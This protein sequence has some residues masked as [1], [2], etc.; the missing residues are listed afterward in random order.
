MAE[1]HDRHMNP[2]IANDI[3]FSLQGILVLFG[4]WLAIGIAKQRLQLN[5]SK[6]ATDSMILAP[7]FVF[8]SVVSLINLW[9][10][11]QPMIMRM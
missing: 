2:L 7:V 8:I 9:L 1:L 3:V 4:F 6:L 5:T 11:M 10:L